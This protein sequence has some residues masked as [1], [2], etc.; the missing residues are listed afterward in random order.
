MLEYDFEQSIGHWLTMSTQ[1]Y[2][3]AFQELIAPF[4]ITYRQA[5]VLGWLA[6]EDEMSQTQLAA[7]MM[8]EPPT[9]A[10]ILDRMERSGWIVR[11][12]CRDDRRRKWICAGPEAEPVWE[13]IAECGHRIR[14]RA[15]RGMTDDEVRQLKRL[16]GQ[17]ARNVSDEEAA[18]IP[19]DTA[20]GRQ[21]RH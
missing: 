8:I 7:R 12:V 13:K 15:T 10:G 6:L 4:G 16:L 19:A 20:L 2:H 5:Q 9:L 21:D 18:T 14:A 17:V 1:S 3:R 11:R